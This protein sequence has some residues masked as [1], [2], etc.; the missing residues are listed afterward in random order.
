MHL[1]NLHIIEWRDKS[2]IRIRIRKKKKKD[3]R[4]MKKEI[5]T[6]IINI[7]LDEIIGSCTQI[8]SY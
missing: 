1:K 4:M 2:I 6:W 3:E 7:Y 5:H 8:I